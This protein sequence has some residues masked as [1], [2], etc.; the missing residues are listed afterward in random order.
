MYTYQDLSAHHDNIHESCL[1]VLRD[2]LPMFE[3]PNPKM[4]L[5]EGQGLPAWRSHMVALGMPTQQFIEQVFVRLRSTGGLRHLS[6]STPHQEHATISTMNSQLHIKQR[7]AE[8]VAHLCQLGVVMMMQVTEADPAHGFVSMTG[9]ADQLQLTQFGR[10]YIEEKQPQTYVGDYLSYLG[11]GIS[12][13]LTLEGYLDEGMTC[14]HLMRQRAAAVMLWEAL[15]YLIGCLEARLLAVSVQT[16]SS[17]YDTALSTHRNDE[18]QHLHRLFEWLEA[19][20]PDSQERLRIE[21]QH[22]L[23]ASIYALW[24]LRQ[25]AMAPTLYHSEVRDHY[26]LFSS[27]CYPIIMRILQCL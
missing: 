7:I 3:P 17:T 20:L 14:L 11:R 23:K 8:E 16:T 5:E 25:R 1:W 26:V 21:V 6:L 12:L 9:S 27:T 10:S 15:N 18:N 24:D 22:Q 19:N 2:S 4:F 13:D